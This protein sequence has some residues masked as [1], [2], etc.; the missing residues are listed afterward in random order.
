MNPPLARHL[1]VTVQVHLDVNHIFGVRTEVYMDKT[2]IGDNKTP[3]TKRNKGHVNVHLPLT[4]NM[5]IITHSGGMLN[6]LLS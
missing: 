2:H 3:S 4:Y 6:S 5:F 1:G